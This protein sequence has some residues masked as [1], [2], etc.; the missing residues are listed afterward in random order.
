MRRVLLPFLLAAAVAAAAVLSACGSSGDSGG[1]NGDVVMWHGYD[2]QLG[3][4]TAELVDQFK[5]TKPGF[6]VKQRYAGPSD[7][8]L[9][10]TL[11]SITA[12]N[13]PD[14][15]YLFGSDMATIARS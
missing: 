5:A 15:V 12:G 7:G 13:F 9:A 3:K 14:V 10:K 2:Q 6:T 11:T 4:V 1:G 8:A